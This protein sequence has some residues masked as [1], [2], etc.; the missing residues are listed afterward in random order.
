MQKTILSTILCLVVL[1]SV[2]AQ[3]TD[4]IGT[5][6]VTV[7]KPYSPTVSDAF[8]I[9]VAP[10]LNDSIVLQ[11]KKITYNIFSVPVASTFTPAKAKAAKVEKLP[12]P[13]LY[14]SYASVGLGNFNNALV[15]FY[16][17]SKLGRDED[18]LDVGLNHHSSRGD[19][20]ST[21]LE[22]DFYNT[23]LDVSYAKKDRDY[24]W[25]A[26]V[27]LQHQLYNWYGLE[28][29]V[30]TQAQIDGI[31]EQQNY[32]NAEA[33]AN[34]TVEDSF[35]KHGDI[36]LRR[37]WD[38]SESGENRVVLNTEIEL[39]ITDELVNF[40]TKVDYVSGSFENDDLNNTVNETGIDYGHFQVGINPSFVVLRDE[41]T[42]NLGANLV[43]GMDIE[44]SS[45]SFYIY[46]TVTAS[47]RVMDEQVIAYAG[48]VGDLKQNSYHDFVNDN[49]FV[50]PTLF[51]QPTD[52]QYEGY[53]GLRGQLFSNVGYNIKGS[54]LAENR[55]PLFFL[56][57]QNVGRTDA[58]GYN[59]GNSFQVFYDD[60]RTFGVFAEL[61]VDVNRKFSFG[62]NAE[63]YNYNTE[64]DNPAWNLPEVKGSLFMDYQ[65]TEQW[66]AGANLFFVGEREDLVSVAQANT[67]PNL[68]PS[69]IV[70]L[71]SFF[72]VNAH[73]GYRFNKQLSAF[74]KFNNLANNS[75]EQWHNFRVQ[76]FQ[77]L[78]GV[79]Y[80]FDL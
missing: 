80:K 18:L 54:Y 72:D 23:K 11:K 60:L 41:L 10:I 26:S 33:K 53:L 43:Y 55:R 46:P 27:G 70:T 6:T 75:Y 40:K 25:G 62:L 47:Y 67:P 52:Q 38:S 34:L 74:A 49:P 73:I 30:F 19:I 57:P 35:F 48:I 1:G 29:G 64:T 51:I 66:F 61:N 63:Y 56:N 14:N 28:S 7:V 8:K 68:F 45:G 2:K 16:T 4:T 44:D 76:S 36:L 58:Q 32:F 9:K 37:F 15:E 79:S 77:A 12:P 42:L 21:P 24:N 20:E 5:E 69:E 71:E 50:S 31:D 65:I 78:A 22:T 59:F 39:P 17:S 13:I 3:E